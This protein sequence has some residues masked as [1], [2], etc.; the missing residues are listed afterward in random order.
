[1]VDCDFFQVG[2]HFGAR[3]D[4]RA[5]KVVVMGYANVVVRASLVLASVC[6]FVGG[7][8]KSA[9]EPVPPSALERAVAED[10]DLGDPR[11]AFSEEDREVDATALLNDPSAESIDF[12][13][14]EA[15]DAPIDHV[16][17]PP[18]RSPSRSMIQDI[19]MGPSGR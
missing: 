14:D 19:T 4:G 2:D 9:D 1:M 10:E 8:A 13:G 7:C 11:D 15:N 17:I 3:V 18:D 16:H 5:A 12:D 6:V